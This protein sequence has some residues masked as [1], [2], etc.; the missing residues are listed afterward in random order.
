MFEP[1]NA[2]RSE[3]KCMYSSNFCLGLPLSSAVNISESSDKK[4]LKKKLGFGFGLMTC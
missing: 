4:V 2:K 1:L 3:Y